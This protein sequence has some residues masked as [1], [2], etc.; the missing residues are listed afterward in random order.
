[1]SGRRMTPEQAREFYKGE[2]MRAAVIRVCID[3]RCGE[4]YVTPVAHPDDPSQTANR[5]PTCLSTVQTASL[6]SGD[7]RPEEDR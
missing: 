1:M 6:A 7:S 4:S 3:E 5:C 2:P